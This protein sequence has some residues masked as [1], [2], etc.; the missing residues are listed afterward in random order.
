[1]GKKTS[2]HG[3]AYQRLS[4][5]KTENLYNERRHESVFGIRREDELE[6][7]DEVSASSFMLYIQVKLTVFYIIQ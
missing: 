6:R 2:Q 3:F 7:K 5:V 1:M 4:I